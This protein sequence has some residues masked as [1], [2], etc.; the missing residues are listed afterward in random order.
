MPDPPRAIQIRVLYSEGCAS[1]PLTVELVKN[2][3]QGLN[4]RVNVE[5]VMV[6]TP[7]QA[8]ELRFPGSPTVLIDGLD[9]E[10]SARDSLSFGLTSRRYG[11]SGVPPEDMVREA[12]RRAS[13]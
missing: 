1:T 10:P 8:Q 6:D 4:K 11:V 7:E 13:Q 9:I 3:A 5:A 12:L 2:I